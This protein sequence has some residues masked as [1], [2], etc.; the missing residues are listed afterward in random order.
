MSGLG[1]PTWT[2]CRRGRGRRTPGAAL[3]VADGL[4]ADVGAVAV[5]QRLDRLDRSVVDGV[6][7]VGRAELAWPS[8]SLRASRSTPMIVRAPASGPGDRGV[9]DA[10]AAEH[11]DGV[12]AATAPVFTAAPNPAMT[13]QP[14]R[15]AASG[16]ARGVDLRGLSGG[17]EGLVGEGADPERGRQ[18]GAVGQS[19]RLGGV[20]GREA[21]PGASSPARSGTRRTRPAS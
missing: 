15:P 3:G 9:P 16:R 19:H 20:V 14:S 18:R 13:P 6:H 11:R 12:A 5:G 1:T 10:A 4:D 8:A 2:T 7:G 21:V 17:D